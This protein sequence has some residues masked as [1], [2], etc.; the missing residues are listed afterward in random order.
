MKTYLLK[1]FSHTIQ[2]FGYKDLYFLQKKGVKFTLILQQIK[3]V[4]T[5]K[6]FIFLLFIKYLIHYSN[7]KGNHVFS[8]RLWYSY[9]ICHIIV[10]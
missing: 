4:E 8:C 5:K 3:I 6:I 1:K 9:L 2:P 10:K 7:G